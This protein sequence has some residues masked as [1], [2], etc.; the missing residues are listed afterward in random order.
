MAKIKKPTHHPSLPFPPTP[1]TLHQEGHWLWI[2]LRKEWCDVSAKP[3][4]IVRQKFV[5]TLVE[6]YGYSL[7]QEE[8]EHQI[9][10]AFSRLNQQLLPSGDDNKPIDT[11]AGRLA[12]QYI[13]GT[14]TEPRAARTAKMNMIMHGDGHGSIHYHDGLL[15]IN[16][17]FNGRL[18]LVL[19]NPPFG[20]NADS[21]QKIG[22][23][24]ETRVPTEATALRQSTWEKFEAALFIATEEPTP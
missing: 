17:I 18:D 21:D 3:E 20:S 7:D 10:A 14:D 22:G 15:D 13:Y 16:G 19:T 1:D 9:E 11:C 4:E 5:R 8:E 23:S 2:P 6:H 24:D 12:W